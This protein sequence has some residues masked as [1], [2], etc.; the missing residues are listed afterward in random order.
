[1]T[2]TSE[3][4]AR[5][6][7]CPD[8]RSFILV[9]K[10]E[11]S[12]SRP[13]SYAKISQRGGFS[14]RSFPRDVATGKKRITASSLYPMIKGLGLKGD[15]ADYFKTLVH[16]EHLETCYPAKDRTSLERKLQNLRDR[17]S[18]KRKVSLG[19]DPYASEFFPFVYAACGVS[20]VGATLKE[21]EKRT[22]LPRSRVEKTVQDLV[23]LGL[24]VYKEPNYIPV[25]SHLLYEGLNE[26]RA[27]QKA[28]QYLLSVSSAKAERNFDSKVDLFFSS[29]F[30][31]RKSQLP[32]LKSELRD[33]LLCYVDSAEDPE[34]DKVASVVCSLI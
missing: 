2:F 22:E 27:F 8:Y 28:F 23:N 25:E 24:L 29:C 19:N 5:L 1:M 3:S 30:S 17:I 6:V 7:Q 18:K 9:Y 13:F 16:I 33:L 26:S 10:E 15:L 31:V 34:G 12:Q 11:R 14:S 20:S 21:I 4:L 32:R